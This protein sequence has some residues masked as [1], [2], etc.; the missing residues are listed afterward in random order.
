MVYPLVSRL[1]FIQLSLLLLYSGDL[2]RLV[3]AAVGTLALTTTN[4]LLELEF[5]GGRLLA[6]TFN[7]GCLRHQIL[8]HGS[9]KGQ[10]LLGFTHAS[11]SHNLVIFVHVVGEEFSLVHL[12]LDDDLLVADRV[13]ANEL[14]AAVVVARPEEWNAT[15][16]NELVEHVERDVGT[17]FQ[18]N[19]PMFNSGARSGWPVRNRSDVTSSVN[20]RLVCLHEWITD[21]AAKTIQLNAR[22]LQELGCWSDACAQDNHISV[23]LT[24]VVQRN[25]LDIAIFSLVGRL[26]KDIV[27]DCHS[28]LFML[29]LI[30]GANLLAKGELE[31]CLLSIDH[32]NI[33]CVLVVHLE[34][35]SAL[36]SDKRS[37]DDHNVLGP[38]ASLFDLSLIFSRAKWEDIGQVKSGYGRL[39]RI[40]A[41]RNAQLVIVDVLATHRDHFLHISVDAEHFCFGLEV[42]VGFLKELRGPQCKLVS[43]TDSKGLRE[44]GPIVGCFLIVGEDRDFA[45]E[46][47]LAESLGAVEAGGATTDDHVVS[48]ILGVAFG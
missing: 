15:I 38:F 20:I 24:S 25:T 47:G 9:Q 41:R 48:L 34:G 26:D 18:S 42:D 31:R 11:Y 32:T 14:Q 12:P 3:L 6:T 27:M 44:Q 1:L 2:L 16:G 10:H 40:R 43:I 45:A 37:T 35:G 33:H 8:L 19:N 7:E 4:V 13:A 29:L 39:P 21:D 30:E 23:E 17:L 22:A 28:I 46:A 5:D 36:R